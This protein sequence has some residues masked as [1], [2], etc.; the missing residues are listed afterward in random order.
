ML[1]RWIQ[2]LPFI[3]RFLACLKRPCRI[4]IGSARR[5]AMLSL[6]PATYV[7][8]FTSLAKATARAWLF[9]FT[10]AGVLTGGPAGARGEV[11]TVFNA[12]DSGAGSLRQA[13]FDASAGD[14]INFALP[15]SVTA[16]LL[17]SG[18]LLINKNLTING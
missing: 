3:E 13:I 7:A 6:Y 16:I 18:E 17:T 8:A 15:Q 10:L 12:N 5:R 9:L 14:T 11:I 4:R 1:R 2:S